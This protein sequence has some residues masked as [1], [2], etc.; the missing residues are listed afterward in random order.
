MLQIKVEMVFET[1][2]EVQD[3]FALGASATPNPQSFTIKNDTPQ[4]VY[5][6]PTTIPLSPLASQPSAT[7]QSSAGAS[8][9]ETAAPASTQATAPTTDPE[10]IAKTLQVEAN[11]MIKRLPS[12]A[13]AVK[14]R[15]ILTKYGFARFRDVGDPTKAAAMIAEFKAVA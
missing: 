12:G 7:Q 5:I 3:F 4:T 10:A 11:E 9:V 1:L 14:A 13:G 15:E 2:K 8:M 6:D